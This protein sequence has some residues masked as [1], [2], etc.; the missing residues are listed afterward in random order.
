MLASLMQCYSIEFH[1]KA[2][3]SQYRGKYIIDGRLKRIKK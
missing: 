1:L 2:L 3:H